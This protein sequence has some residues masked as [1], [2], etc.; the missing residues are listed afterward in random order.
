[1]PKYELDSTGSTGFSGR[2]LWTGRWTV[3]N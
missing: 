1:M 2:L 3:G